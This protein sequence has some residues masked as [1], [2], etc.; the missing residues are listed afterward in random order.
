M[1]EKTAC[2]YYAK[3]GFCTR[4]NDCNWRGYSTE[5]GEKKSYFPDLW[6]I[7]REKEREEERFREAFHLS[8]H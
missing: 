6:A 3:C 8:K 5:T 1:T 2:G 7:D 4:R